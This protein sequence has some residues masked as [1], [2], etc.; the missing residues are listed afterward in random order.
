MY[1]TQQNTHIAHSVYISCAFVVARCRRWMNVYLLGYKI[2]T[3]VRFIQFV[4]SSGYAPSIALSSVSLFYVLFSFRSRTAFLLQP[5]VWSM[6]CCE[7]CLRRCINSYFCSLLRSNPSQPKINFKTKKEE[8]TL[9]WK[10]QFKKQRKRQYA[11][12][13]PASTLLRCFVQISRLWHNKN[14]IFF[15]SFR[16]YIVLLGL[17]VCFRCFF[18]FFFI[19]EL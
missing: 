19:F 4:H 13:T 18:G 12:E 9:S 17:F 15:A 8:N 2:C 14:N 3:H 1:L 16:V 6:E 5:W 7:L 11:E 10:Y